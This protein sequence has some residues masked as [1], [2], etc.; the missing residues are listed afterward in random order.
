MENIMKNDRQ[1]NIHV[2]EE[3]FALIN[4]LYLYMMNKREVLITKP[5]FLKEVLLKLCEKLPKET[6]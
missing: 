1:F 3:E 2:T 5:A 4:R 6:K